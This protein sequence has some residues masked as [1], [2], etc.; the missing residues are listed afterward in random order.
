M[1]VRTFDG[2]T[3]G[4]SQ[5][6]ALHGAFGDLGRVQAMFFDASTHR[7]YYTLR[8]DDT[9]HYRYF[10]PQDGLVGT[11]RYSAPAFLV[12]GTVYFAQSQTGNLRSVGWNSA[13]ATTVGPLKNL[14]GPS[15]DG[16]DYRAHGLVALD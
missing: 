12:D 15:I 4:P 5:S 3:L 10:E 7:I 2:T 8:G 9:L 14:L 13:A 1:T 6:V 16:T 11:W